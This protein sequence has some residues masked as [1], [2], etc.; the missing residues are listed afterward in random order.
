MKLKKKIKAPQESLMPE[1]TELSN[2]NLGQERR[3][4]ALSSACCGLG[5]VQLFTPGICGSR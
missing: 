5:T 4:L 1:V 2:T 3:E